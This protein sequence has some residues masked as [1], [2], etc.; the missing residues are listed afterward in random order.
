MGDASI[1]IAEMIEHAN[2]QPHLDNIDP[3]CHL[4]DSR[5]KQTKPPPQKKKKNTSSTNNGD[6]A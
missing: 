2:L 3:N 4:G 5:A 1:T 6:R